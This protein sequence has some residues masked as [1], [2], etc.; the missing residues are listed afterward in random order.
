MLQNMK[1]SIA[2]AAGQDYR[3]AQSGNNNRLTDENRRS[4]SSQ[5]PDVQR[6]N[7]NG[8]DS[9]N[10][11]GGSRSQNGS[12]SS[13]SG[14]GSQGSGDPGNTSGGQ[15]SNNGSVAAVRVPRKWLGNRS[16][17]RKYQSGCRIPG[18]RLI[19][20]HGQKG[21]AIPIPMKNMS[22]YMIL[23]DWGTAAR[24]VM[25]PGA[26]RTG[27]GEQVET[28]RGL[29]SFD[30]FI[31]YKEVFGSY[32]RQAMENLKHGYPTCHA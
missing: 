8:T 14:N 19:V 12:S 15:G 7:D 13:G 9:L 24:K 22:V 31:P 4:G 17:G 5:T 6:P 25:F 30:G 2:N 1:G 21:R 3:I 28:G 10:A 18:R 11:A 27:Y 32:S 26:N 20:G 23:S 16:R 29:G